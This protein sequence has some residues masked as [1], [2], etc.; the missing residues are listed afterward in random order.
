MLIEKVEVKNFRSIAEECLD[1]DHL[2]TLVGRNGAGKSAFLQAIDVFYDP[3]ASVTEEDYYDRDVGNPIE[4]RITY[5]RLRGDELEEFRP[6]VRDNKLMVTKRITFENGRALPRYYAVA[7]EIPKFAEIRRMTRKADRRTAWNEL[8][9]GDQLPGLVKRASSADEAERL[10]AEYEAAHPD[11]M[12]P[13]E[14]EEQ[15]FGPRNVG[16]GKL[17]KFTKYVLVPAVRDASDEAQGKKGAVYQI[18]DMIVL[19]QIN[20]REDVQ[21]FRA[22]FEGKVKQLYSSENLKE[23]PELGAS[24]S[25]TL[26]EFAPG[27]RFNLGAWVTSRQ[28]IGRRQLVGCGSNLHR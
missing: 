28:V 16:G 25:R 13:T 22:E 9:G 11:L 19:R 10:M 17:D 1:C 14:R 21:K 7:M 18:L 24:I 15:F 3:G 6:Y 8:V 20:A 12:E 4:I 23:L 5:T 2:T 27:S 26:A